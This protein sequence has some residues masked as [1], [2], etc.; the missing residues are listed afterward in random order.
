M[1]GE[2]TLPKLTVGRTARH[3]AQQV[4]VDFDDFLYGLRGDVGATGSTRING[5]N[6]TTLILERQSGRAPVKVYLYGRVRFFELVQK[7]FWLFVF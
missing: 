6:H 2:N 4:R 3:C 5:Y 1:F 7:G